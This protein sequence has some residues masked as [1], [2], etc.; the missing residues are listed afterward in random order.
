[1]PK[2]VYT[3]S[4]LQARMRARRPQLRNPAPP[5]RYFPHVFDGYSRDAFESRKPKPRLT[6]EEIQLQKL[7]VDPMDVFLLQQ[8]QAVDYWYIYITKMINHRR[9]REPDLNWEYLQQMINTFRN[10][11]AMSRMIEVQRTQHMVEELEQM[12]W[13]MQSIEVQLTMFGVEVGEER[14]SHVERHDS[15]TVESD[16]DRSADGVDSLTTIEIPIADMIQ[17]SNGDDI[18]DDGTI[19]PSVEK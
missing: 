8:L 10:W 17:W 15:I 6:R 7:G 4:K 2:R 3:R 18:L 11:V 14:A 12:A 5:K 13:H 19:M 16:S 1:M 9:Q